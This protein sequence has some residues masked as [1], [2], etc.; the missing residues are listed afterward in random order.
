EH[1]PG[2]YRDARWA[3]AP[4]DWLRAR[5]TGEIHA[6]PSD[7]SASLLYDVPGDRWDL[8]V[9]GALG[10]DA[11]LLAPVLPSAGAQAGH[12]TAAARA[13]RADR[14]TRSSSRTCRGNGHRTAIRRCAAPGP[15]C[16][17][18]MTGRRCCGARSRA[19]RSRSATRWTR[20][21][22]TPAPESSARRGCGWRA[23]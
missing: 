10:L 12:L 2:T 5:L 7:A 17:W 6:E 19:S 4:K 21:S 15:R 13:A 9:V 23:G 8:D 20:C 18:P 11:G 14:T 3:L 22:A 16:R 1:E